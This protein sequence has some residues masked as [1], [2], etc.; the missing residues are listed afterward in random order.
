MDDKS[1]GMPGEKIETL[2]ARQDIKGT[3]N[4]Y[5]RNRQLQ[6]MGHLEGTPTELAHMTGKGTG[7]FWENHKA[8][9]TTQHLTSLFACSIYGF[10]AALIHHNMS[11][12]FTS[13]SY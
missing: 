1:Q 6:L 4:G 5:R 7:T 11:G 9:A 8:D 10:R 12:S 2:L 13:L 3:V